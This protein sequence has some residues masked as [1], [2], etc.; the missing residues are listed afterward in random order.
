MIKHKGM[1]TV[2]FLAMLATV[3]CSTEQQKVAQESNREAAENRVITNAAAVDAKADSFV[4]I[5]FKPGSSALTN[6]AKESLRSVVDQ[7]RTYGRI[8]D[9]IVLS[10]ADQEYPSK[11]LKKLSV[12]QRNLAD[13]R[14]KSIEEYVKSVRTVDVDAYNMAERPNVLSK[15]MNTSDAKLKDSFVAAGLSTTADENQ[16]PSKAS[17][18]VILVKVK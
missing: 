6:N 17:H 16:Y 11:S 1:L 9:L 13:S 7:A 2:G 4:E 10:W 12:G 5:K 14:N 15:W 8:D 18:S 3:G